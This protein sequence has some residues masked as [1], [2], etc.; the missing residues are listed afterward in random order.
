MVLKFTISVTFVFQRSLEFPL[1]P[2]SSSFATPLRLIV[3]T[4]LIVLS[5]RTGTRSCASF[6]GRDV[7]STGFVSSGPLDSDGQTGGSGSNRKILCQD[8]GWV[9]EACH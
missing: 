6:W 4:S 9:S 3:Q 8:K 2:S 7:W 1:V 5:A